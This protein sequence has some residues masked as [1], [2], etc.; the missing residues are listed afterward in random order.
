MIEDVQVAGSINRRGIEQTV[1]DDNLM[2][3]LL[4][5]I[6]TGVGLGIG[7]LVVKK[8]EQR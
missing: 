5:A 2:K 6:V 4:L 7:L 8:L 1:E 3:I